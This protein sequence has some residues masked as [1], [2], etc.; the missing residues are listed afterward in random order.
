MMR[1]TFILASLFLLPFLSNAQTIEGEVFISSAGMEFSVGDDLTIGYPSLGTEF[2]FIEN[3]T[4]KKIGLAGKLAG[5]ATNVATSVAIVG[6]GAGSYGTVATGIQVAGT[7]SAVE[8]VAQAGDLIIKGEHKLT[9]QRLRILKFFQKGNP[10]RGEHF[11]A[12]VAGIGKE[13]YNIELDRAID[14]QEVLGVNGNLFNT[15]SQQ[16]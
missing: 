12:T 13:N 6:V 1:F 11:Y 4:K 9:G 7:A 3:N 2:S 5:A 14:A 8:G 10:K 16:D 15:D